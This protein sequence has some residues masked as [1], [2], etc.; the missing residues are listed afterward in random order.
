LG[1]DPYDPELRRTDDH[2]VEWPET[3]P[4]CQCP[5]KSAARWAGSAWSAPDW[6][7]S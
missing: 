1:D 7:C 5:R 6:W 3:V 4:R 2:R